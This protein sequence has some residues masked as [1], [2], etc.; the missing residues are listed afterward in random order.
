MSDTLARKDDFEI[1]RK[2]LAKLT[3]EELKNYFWELADNVVSPLILLAKNHTSPAIERSVL[4]RMGF[5]SLE[6]KAIVDKVIQH[7]LISKG[8]GNVVYR[9]SV[10]NKIPI[11]ESGLILIQNFGWEALEASFEVTK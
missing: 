2:H 10:I 3:D 6:A 7:H 1:R 9:F 11:R 8:A 4:L 5:S